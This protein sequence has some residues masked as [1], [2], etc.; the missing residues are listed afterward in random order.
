MDFLVIWN[1]D[2]IF[3]K[4]FRVRPWRPLLWSQLA[5]TAK[6]SHF[7]GQMCPEQET[8]QFCRF[9]SAIVHGLFGDLEFRHNFCQNLSWTSV[10]TLDMD[11]ISP[12]G[13][14]VPFCRS[15]VTQSRKTSNFAD[16][17]VLIH[18]LFGDLDF[19][20]YFCQNLSWTTVKTLTREP[21]IP[22]GQ[23]IPFLKSNLPRIR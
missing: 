9:S 17:R 11:P 4:N 16:F 6:T 19:P 22:H 12:R 7:K 13:Q 3:A 5:F 20:T 23:N 14:N 15:N 10:K 1:S 8:P 2:I 21:V 18:G